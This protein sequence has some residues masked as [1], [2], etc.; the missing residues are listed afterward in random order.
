MVNYTNAIMSH[1]F[2]TVHRLHKHS[3]TLTTSGVSLKLP[4]VYNKFNKELFDHDIRYS[5]DG[6]DTWCLMV[7]RVL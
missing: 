7:G 4:F 2:N 3:L 1:W 6:A 5:H